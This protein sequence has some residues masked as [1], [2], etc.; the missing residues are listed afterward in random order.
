MAALHGP[1]T[2]RSPHPIATPERLSPAINRRDLLAL[3]PEFATDD[4][5]CSAV[6]A[7]LFGIQL[8][9]PRPAGGRRRPSC[10]FIVPVLC[11]LVSVPM[12]PMDARP[13][14]LI[15]EPAQLLDVGGIGRN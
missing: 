1:V 14:A 11:I 12:Y 7:L 13:I 15:F 10:Q 5:A 8:S 2:C 4:Q 6:D 9:R 3:V